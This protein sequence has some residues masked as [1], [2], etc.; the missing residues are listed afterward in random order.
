MISSAARVGNA[1]RCTTSSCWTILSWLWTTVNVSA[2]GP[3]P[4]PVLSYPL[5]LTAQY[6]TRQG[7]GVLALINHHHTVDDDRR[8]PRRIL[9]RVV[10]R[11]PVGDLLRIKHGDVGAVA[12]T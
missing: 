7:V 6:L 12:L 8:N 1:A 10:E 4:P 11:G 3:L 2:T 9:M 5:R